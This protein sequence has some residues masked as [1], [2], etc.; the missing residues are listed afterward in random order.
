MLGSVPAGLTP[1]YDVL[2]FIA[3]LG[4]DLARRSIETVEDV[5][6]RDVVAIR[7]VAFITQVASMQA[8]GPVFRSFPHHAGC[9][10]AV[11]A[12]RQYFTQVRGR[13]DL[14]A[15]AKADQA[16]QGAAQHSAVSAR[17]IQAHLAARCIAELLRGCNVLATTQ[18]LAIASAQQRQE[19]VHI[20]LAVR[21]P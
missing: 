10:Q 12:L 9:P 4:D 13:I 5:Q 21:P 2:K 14:A 3:S 15:I 6:G 19:T 7:T 16:A 8:E 1:G 20:P 11:A 17:Q 18:E